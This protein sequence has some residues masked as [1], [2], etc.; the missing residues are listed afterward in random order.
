MLKEK[1]DEEEKKRKK[2]REDLIAKNTDYSCL[3]SKNKKMK[4]DLDATMLKNKDLEVKNLDWDKKI[5]EM[6]NEIFLIIQRIELNTLLK[7]VDME[8]LK[9]LAKNNANMNKAF[10]L[11]VGK[12]NRIFE[13]KPEDSK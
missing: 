1:S 12:W 3:V 11:M 4:E 5:K 6:E 13:M 10:D 9:L 8:D 2:N 7:D